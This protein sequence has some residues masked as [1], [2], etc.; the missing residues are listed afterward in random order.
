M[1][2]WILLRG[3]TREAAHWGAFAEAFERALPGAR[4]VAQDLP[5]NGLLH[6]AV[7]PVTVRGMVERCRA[8]LAERGLRPPFSVL[9]MS[10]GAMVATEWARVAPE[11]L[12]GCVLINTSLRPFSPFYHRLRPRNYTALLR[13]AFGIKREEQAEQEVLR[14]TS[15]CVLRRQQVVPDWAEIRRQR[16]VSA[17]NTLRQLGAAACYRAPEKAPLANMLLLASREDGLV[18]GQCSQ[19]IANAWQVPVEFHPWAGHDLPLDDPRWVI[20]KVRDWTAADPRSL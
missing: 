9:A 16:P 14:L 2:P 7:S 19:A 18:H 5:G 15:N 1:H 10:L 3:L 4:V 17:A 6:R 13:L 20:E 8:E 12:A 11:E